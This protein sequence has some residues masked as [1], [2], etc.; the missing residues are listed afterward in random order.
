MQ[1]AQMNACA[2]RHLAEPLQLFAELANAQMRSVQMQIAHNG[3]SDACILVMV[4]QGCWR[5]EAFLPMDFHWLCLQWDALATV[6]IFFVARE[7]VL[8]PKTKSGN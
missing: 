4:R 5:L 8:V 6:Q 1:I 2:S 3:E 7:V